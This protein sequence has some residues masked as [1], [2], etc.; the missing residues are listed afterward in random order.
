MNRYSVL[1]ETVIADVQHVYGGEC[2]LVQNKS[3]HVKAMQGALKEVEAAVRAAGGDMCDADEEE[4][5]AC[6]AYEEDRYYFE[7]KGI[8]VTGRVGERAHASKSVE[9]RA[10]ISCWARR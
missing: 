2:E 1:G 7:V 5:S 9:Q 8:C 4:E 3:L 6:A 10:S